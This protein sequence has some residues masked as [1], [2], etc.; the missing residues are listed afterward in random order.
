MRWDAPTLLI[1]APAVGLL[2]VGLAAWARLA[3]IRRAGRWSDELAQMARSA[4]AGA[5]PLGAAAVLAVLALAGPR[6][7]RASITTETRSLDLVIAV[8][9]SRSMRARDTPPDRLERARAEAR[10]LVQDLAGDRIGLIAF[11]GRSFILSPL[12]VDAGALLLLLDALDP[13]MTSA[14]GSSITR[15]LRQGRELLSA[16]NQI[17][18]RVLVVFTDGE[19]HDSL[20]AAVAEA[21]QLLQ[22][23]VRL[24]LVAEGRPEGATIPVADTGEFRDA[25]GVVVRTQ[26]RDDILTRLADAAEG[27]LV[28]EGLPDQ[29]AAVRELVA[30]Y[31]RAPDTIVGG[32]HDVQ[33]AWVLLV[34]AVLVLLVHATT[35]RTAALA[36]WCLVAL[37]SAATAQTPRHPAEVHWQEGRL[38]D[39]AV[40]WQAVAEARDVDTAWF[41]LGT[42]L[43]ATGDEAG[44]RAALERAAGSLDPEVRYRALF[45]L[46]LLD[47]RLAGADA[48]NRSER[49]A[50]ARTRYREALLLRPGDAAARWNYEL[51]LEPA[52][53]PSSGGGGGDPPPDDPQ[54]Q[55]P[56]ER[57]APPASLSPEQARQIL[58]SIAQDERATR[59]ELQRR[60]AMARDA[61]AEKDW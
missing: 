16:G 19:A 3:R 42:A 12:T 6:Y 37:P 46:G 14:G 24:V 44:A 36:A 48:A 33:R 40:A 43:L 27:I 54:D 22:Q 59:R 56:E 60:N 23:G 15:V 50:A 18:D 52:P 41:N 2:V 28:P 32:Q 61:R 34:L 8:D 58:Q 9:V 13:E 39:A 38:A 31:Q 1:F 51:T 10:R 55:Q 25:M 17:A 11:A 30:S 35:R 29:A 45:N 57:Q 4:R 21:Q 5:V 47:L 20:E 53:P 26:R 49:L 7:G